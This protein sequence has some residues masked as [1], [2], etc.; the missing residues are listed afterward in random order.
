FSLTVFLT[1]L[2]IGVGLLSFIRAIGGTG[3]AGKWITVAVA[4][5]TA[6]FGLL[7]LFDYLRSRRSG[8]T[9]ST[10]GLSA[11]VT[12][13]IHRA[14]REHTSTGYLVAGAVVLGVVITVL[15]LGCTGQVYLPTITFVARAGGDRLRAVLYLALYC[16]MFILPLVVVFLLSYFGTGQKK[17]VA[18]GRKHAA[19]LKLAGGLVLIG[20]SVLLF[21]TV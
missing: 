15:E 7:A 19:N 4:S 11:G 21:I 20:L 14:I 13:R 12:R 3:T 16:L 17:L 9:E 1:Y 18:F 8:K 2:L 10:L 6:A 5:L